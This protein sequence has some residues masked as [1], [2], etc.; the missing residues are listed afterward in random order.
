MLKVV[1][2]IYKHTFSI[3]VLK[4]LCTNFKRMRG[5]PAIKFYV[6][7]PQAGNES[8]S[9]NYLTSVLLLHL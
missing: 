9:S 5:R 3:Y 4:L 6:V 7:F 8:L 1:N 2:G